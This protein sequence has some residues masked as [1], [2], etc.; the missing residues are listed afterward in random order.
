VSEPSSSFVGYVKFAEVDVAFVMPPRTTIAEAMRAKILTDKANL[1][2]E[3]STRIAALDNVL[4]R[5][6]KG[7]PT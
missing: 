2:E 6:T 1:V 3:S 5:L 4:Q 7:D